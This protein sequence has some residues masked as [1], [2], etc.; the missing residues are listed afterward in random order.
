M[1]AS[2]AEPYNVL[3]L[4]IDDLNDWVGC[5]GGHPQARTPN[6]DRLAN[7][8]VLFTNAHCPAPACNPSR[9][10][11]FTGIGPST[12]GV[13]H[14]H[15]PWRRSGRLASTVTLP[16]HFMAHGYT[17]IRAGKVFH[18]DPPPLA[19]WDVQWPSRRHFK[20]SNPIDY[21]NTHIN[22]IPDA[23]SF[24]WGPVDVEPEA[25]GDWRLAEWVA[26]QL[27]TKHEEPFF[28]AAGTTQPHLE[29]YSPREYIDR[30]P[31]DEIVLPEVPD[32]DLDD[33]PPR[34]VKRIARPDQYH[35]MVLRHDEW[36]RAVQGYLANIAFVD[37]CVGVILDGLDEGPNRTDTVVVL[38]SDH[39]QHLGEKHH[40]HKYSLW[41]EATRVPLIVV[42]P[43]VT[44][45]GTRCS[46]PVNLIDLYPTLAE[47]CDLPRQDAAE[48][49]SLLPLLR[50]GRAAWS[51]PAVT[52][53][54]RNNHAVRSEQWRYILYEDGTEEL[55]DHRNDP[56]EWTNLADR[57]GFDAVKRDLRASLPA[58]NAPDSFS[59]RPA[60]KRGVISLRNRIMKALEVRPWLS[61]TLLSLLALA[62][63]GAALEIG[64]RLF[65]PRYRFAAESGFS[66]DAMRIMARQPDRR[67]RRAHPDTGERHWVMHNN[68]ALR[69][70]R[71]MTPE[72]IDGGV[73]LG[74][75]GDSF[76]EN[77]RLD[78]PYSFQES[79]DFLLNETGDSTRYNVLN[80]GVDGY[81]TD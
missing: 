63:C 33:V 36:R 50:D 62:A 13:Y 57:A 12:S 16:E 65:Y 55:Y 20:Q 81:G 59:T 11:V 72:E 64:L 68:L 35:A 19:F 54:G 79:L 6:I 61:R 5:L 29:W 75:F 10:A 47:L 34:A 49:I 38:W 77:V 40:W 69:Q 53:H 15:Q 9:A 48:G 78:A 76:T 52:T 30:F 27:R 60:L 24:D 31:L 22:R 71:N 2:G 21:P 17:S 66:R 46:R 41:E 39:G 14:N 1:L 8:G 28:L 51:R 58:V 73:N 32:D 25:M 4:S 26:D 18:G 42:A 56:R 37:D 74:F 7:R 67:V 70:H 43:G 23:G 80:L 45:P 44:P 3:F